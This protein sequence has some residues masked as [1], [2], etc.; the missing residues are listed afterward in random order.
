[1]GTDNKG[2]T[3]N[4]NTG[5]WNTGNRNT[6]NLNTGNWN[7]GYWNTGNLNT[8]NWNTGYWN[9]GYW[10][11]GYWNTGNRN[12]GNWNTGNWNTGFFNTDEPT[13]R[14]FNRDTGLTQY[15]LP[16]MPEFL[17]F[18][19]SEWVSSEDMSYE[20][21]QQHPEHET[22]GGY[23]KE[24]NYKVAFQ[25]SFDENVTD[26]QIEQLKELPNFNA[27]IFYK[28]SGIDLNPREKKTVTL[29]LTEEQLNSLKEQ[30]I[31]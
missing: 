16:A 17:F 1:M 11:T 15:E 23:L 2:N 10:N 29:E 18:N 28:I 21:K 26:E 6:G 30:G 19:T 20:E 24:L 4:R 12:T 27:D 22:I 5:N 3:G 14:M 25:K 31:V 7:T 9:T 8:G 13:V